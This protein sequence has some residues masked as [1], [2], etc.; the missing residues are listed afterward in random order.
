MALKSLAE[1]PVEKTRG[2][3]KG[4]G[5]LLDSLIEDRQKEAARG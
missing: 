5:S 2:M 1:D 4:K 3:L